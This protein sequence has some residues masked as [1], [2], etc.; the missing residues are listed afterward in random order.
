MVCI[1]GGEQEAASASGKCQ[2]ALT[3]LHLPAWDPLQSWS[4]AGGAASAL[5]AVAAAA[6][7]LGLEGSQ[8]G[9][10][11]RPPASYWSA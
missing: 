10:G 7:T 8:G 4:R 3:P 1:S 5:P 6:A 2:I 11:Q 9:G